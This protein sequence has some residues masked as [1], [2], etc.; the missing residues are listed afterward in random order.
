M[1][2]LGELQSGTP[3]GHVLRNRLTHLLCEASSGSSAEAFLGY[4]GTDHRLS[5]H[6]SPALGA[7]P[8]IVLMLLA[9]PWGLDILQLTALEPDRS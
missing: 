2:C 6:F 8:P 1:W 5:Q 4:G 3:A 9:D 7:N